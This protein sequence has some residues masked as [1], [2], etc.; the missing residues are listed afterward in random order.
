MKKAFI[1]LALAVTLG[2][3]VASEIP[4]LAVFRRQERQRARRQRYQSLCGRPDALVE[5]VTYRM[6]QTGKFQLVER[7]DLDRIIA[8]Y[9]LLESDWSA[10]PGWDAGL[11]AA[12]YLL[13]VSVNR[14]DETVKERTLTIADVKIMEYRASTRVSLSLIEVS[15]GKITKAWTGTKTASA[16]EIRQ[17]T[18]FAERRDWT[19]A[20][21]ADAGIDLLAEKLVSE[22]VGPSEKI[23]RDEPEEPEYPK[24]ETPK[25]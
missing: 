13:I 21:W 19:E 9:Y 12:D 17:N 22:L 6:A 15:T 4:S 16:R 24:M 23:E 3:L 1:L 8:E 25:W 10:Q 7:L 5:A 14:V 18:S 11:I 2:N 20:A